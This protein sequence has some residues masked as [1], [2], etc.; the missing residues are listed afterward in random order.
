LVIPLFSDIVPDGGGTVI[1]P[2]AIATVAKWLH[3]HP[4]GVSPRMVPR[5]Q[6]DFT[7]ERNFAWFIDVAQPANDADF[8][9]VT[10]QTGDVFLLHPL[11]LVRFGYLQCVFEAQLRELFVSILP[12]A[13]R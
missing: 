3:D 2:P 6:A 5:G 7:K 11:M 13:T 8:V 9:E 10:G 1:L 12:P 4:E